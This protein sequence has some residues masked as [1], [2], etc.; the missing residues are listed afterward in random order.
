MSD[1]T[2][3][4]GVIARAI[5]PN[6]GFPTECIEDDCAWWVEGLTDERRRY[7][8]VAHIGIDARN[9]VQER[10]GRQLI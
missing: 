3:P 9:S 10:I 2:C 1:K 6:G 7:C 5:F 8:A 4:L